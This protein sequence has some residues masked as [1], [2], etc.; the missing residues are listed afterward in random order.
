LGFFWFWIGSTAVTRTISAVSIR[1]R[2]IV[3]IRES[4]SD[5]LEDYDAI[6]FNLWRL[7][8]GV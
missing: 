5:L 1:V 7:D 8:F 3:A 2:Q 6:K 4:A